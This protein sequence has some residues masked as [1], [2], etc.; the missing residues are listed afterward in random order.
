MG[1]LKTKQIKINQ[2]IQVD[3]VVNDK[4]ANLYKIFK[5]KFQL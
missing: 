2:N 4:I 3:N 1:F 5:S